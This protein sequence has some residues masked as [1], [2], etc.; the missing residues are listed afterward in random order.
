MTV[1]IDQRQLNIAIIHF[2]P[3]YTYQIIF[4]KHTMGIV[5]LW[6]GF[7]NAVLELFTWNGS[8][9][10]KH[11]RKADW[12]LCCLLRFLKEGTSIVDFS[13]GPKPQQLN[14][15]FRS[16]GWWICFFL[17]EE[18]EEKTFEYVS[19]VIESHLGRNIVHICVMR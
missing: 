12:D 16:L 2:L 11:G 9:W 13:L 7:F 18:E 3:T 6:I 4:L 15:D 14:K 1:F 5:S 17:S 10:N 19:L 8:T